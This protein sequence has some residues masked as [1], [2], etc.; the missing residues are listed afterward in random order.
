M[1]VLV[2]CAWC[3]RIRLDGW[4]SAK[5]ALRRLRTYERAEPPTFGHG[6]CDECLERLVRRRELSHTE[7]EAA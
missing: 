5:V 7:A 3:E 6:M 1:S 2:A 4:V